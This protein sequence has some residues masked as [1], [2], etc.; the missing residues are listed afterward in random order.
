MLGV[1]TK[2]VTLLRAVKRT[3]FAA[4]MPQRWIIPVLLLGALAAGSF[5]VGA[6]VGGRVTG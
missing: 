2:L 6:A 4:P 5:G 1:L 3:W